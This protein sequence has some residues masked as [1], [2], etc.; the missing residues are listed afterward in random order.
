VTDRVKDFDV[1]KEQLV[2]DSYWL[3]FLCCIKVILIVIRVVVEE[4]NDLL[5]LGFLDN[6]YV[7]PIARCVKY[8]P[9]QTIEHVY[10][11]S[12]L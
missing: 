9:A 4:S 11:T 2:N 10:Y 5:V 3:F 8:K 6:L 7:F 1:T 12:T